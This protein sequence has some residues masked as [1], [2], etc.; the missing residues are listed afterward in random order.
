MDIS[1]DEI[2]QCKRLAVVFGRSVL[3]HMSPSDEKTLLTENLRTLMS[4]IR[5]IERQNESDDA[6]KALAS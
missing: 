3:E 2:I 6:L 5:K 4:V 1:K